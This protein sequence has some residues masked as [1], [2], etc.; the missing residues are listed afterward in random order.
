MYWV[1]VLWAEGTCRGGLSEEGPGL[2]PV[3]T[4][5]SSWLHWTHWRELSLSA[6]TVVWNTGLPAT[7]GTDHGKAGCP[8]ETHKGQIPTL[9]PM[10]K[11]TMEQLPK[12]ALSD[13][14]LILLVL[15]GNN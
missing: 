6:E 8:P 15:I 7:L 12:Q 14:F 4:A 11:H 3:H 2:P 9:F 13:L 1:S 10:E 5:T